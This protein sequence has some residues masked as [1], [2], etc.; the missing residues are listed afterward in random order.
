MASLPFNTEEHRQAWGKQQA[1]YLAAFPII[2]EPVETL[3]FF[4]DPTRL[5]SFFEE[6][7]RRKD[8]SA[9]AFIGFLT[10]LGFNVEK[11][12]EAISEAKKELAGANAQLRAVLKTNT[13]LHEQIRQLN[14]V[15]KNDLQHQL[16]K[17][18]KNPNDSK[19]WTWKAAAQ[20]FTSLDAQDETIYLK[21]DAGIKLD[22][23]FQKKTPFPN[24]IVLF[25]NLS[26]RCRKTEEQKVKAL[27]KNVSVEIAQ[28][29]ATLDSPQSVDDFDGWVKKCARFY[30]NLQEYEHHQK[31]KNHD[32]PY[33]RNNPK[34]QTP[35]PATINMGDPM[36][37][38]RAELISS[39]NSVPLLLEDVAIQTPLVVDSQDYDAEDRFI[40]LHTQKIQDLVDSMV[41][42]ME[43]NTVTVSTTT[44]PD[45]D[46]DP[47]PDMDLDLVGSLTIM[48]KDTDPSNT[49]AAPFKIVAGSV[50]INRASIIF[51]QCKKIGQ[52]GGLKTFNQ[53]LRLHD[54]VPEQKNI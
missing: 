33:Q 38:H 11:K 45:P 51:V 18:V 9:K 44:D 27:K 10:I 29:L 4:K 23:L 34:P 3:D 41:Q 47:D 36:Q 14:M 7:D 35:Q 53:K 24:F 25:Q 20:L 2:A 43:L 21:L 12:N 48:E 28:K 52:G 6:P 5:I 13:D 19:L 42:T 46:P 37:P 8:Q 54:L 26:Q 39:Q 32:N 17:A 31:A 16:T 50:V 49:N 40:T 15:D 22:V 1:A 30:E